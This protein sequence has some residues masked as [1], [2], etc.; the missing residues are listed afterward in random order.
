MPKPR[1]CHRLR[2]KVCSKVRYRIRV[3]GRPS[4]LMKSLSWDTS[5]QHS[6]DRLGLVFSTTHGWAPDQSIFGSLKRSAYCFR[7]FQSWQYVMV[8]VRLPCFG[9]DP[10]TPPVTLQRLAGGGA[11]IRYRPQKR[12]RTIHGYIYLRSLTQAIE[13]TG[14][15]MR[16]QAVG[17]FCFSTTD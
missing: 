12:Q 8:R 4:A 13:Y 2:R 3:R 1:S 15:G 16:Q 11:V 14:T 17:A 6:P 5:T 7:S 10:L 9:H